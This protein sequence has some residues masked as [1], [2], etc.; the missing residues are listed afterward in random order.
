[1][2]V[3]VPSDELESAEAC[4]AVLQRVLA[5]LGPDDLAKQTPCRE[6]DVASLTDHLMNSITVIGGAAGAKFPERGTSAPVERQVM[7]AADPALRA[8]RSRGLDGM[9]SLGPNETPAT[10]MAGIL[11]IEFLVHAWDYAAATGQ[12]LD[13]PAPLCEYVLGLSRGIITPEGRGNVGF[14]D[15]VHVPAEAGAFDRLL[16]F[17]GRRGQTR[18]R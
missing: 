12:E 8:W 4:L 16:A 2:T 9:V 10:V 3:D 11:S 17:T 7:T 1:M 14:D 18:S 6:F 5:E 15:E 13:P